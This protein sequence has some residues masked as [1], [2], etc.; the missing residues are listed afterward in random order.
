MT[1]AELQDFAEAHKTFWWWV[2]DVRALDEESIVQGTLNYG[3]WDDVQEL[4][5]IMG[6]EAAA[7]AFYRDI[8][9]SARRRG[10]YHKK[11]LGFFLDYFKRH[12][13]GVYA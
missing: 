6:I 1:S 9:V 2:K 12:A 11:T 4:I 10:N 13:S 3:D 5:R 8:N 7:R